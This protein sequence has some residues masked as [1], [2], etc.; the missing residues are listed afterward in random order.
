MMF[1]FIK[2]KEIIKKILYNMI[3]ACERKGKQ[4]K[5]TGHGFFFADF[6]ICLFANNTKPIYAAKN[7]G[8]KL[9]VPGDVKAVSDINTAIT[10]APGGDYNAPADYVVNGVMVKDVGTDFGIADECGYRIKLTLQGT[11]IERVA[12][13]KV[14][15]KS[16][17]DF[18]FLVSFLGSF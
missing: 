16:K 14:T 4:K 2:V 12:A 9:S 8:S 1:L 7:I 5:E 3:W 6:F 18:I 11:E 15:F 10:D 17:T 13:V